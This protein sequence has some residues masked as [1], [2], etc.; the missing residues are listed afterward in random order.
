M[1]VGLGEFDQMEKITVLIIK[2]KLILYVQEI[3]NDVSM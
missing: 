2:C 1:F 3:A